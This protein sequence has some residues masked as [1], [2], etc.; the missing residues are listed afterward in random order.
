MDEEEARGKC[1]GRSGRKNLNFSS[2]NLPIDIHRKTTSVA[3]LS[4]VL[5]LL[6]GACPLPVRR[7]DRSN[8]N[9][10]LPVS[11]AGEDRRGIFRQGELRVHL[12]C[13]GAIDES[14]D[15]CTS[16]VQVL[17]LTFTYDTH[18]V[19]RYLVVNCA[20][21]RETARMARVALYTFQVTCTVPTDSAARPD[22]RS[23]SQQTRSIDCIQLYCTF[24]FSE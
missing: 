24:L 21:V 12:P 16:R 8:D 17:Y 20:Y 18:C 23:E 6:A 7:R 22:S 11:R 4:P 1:H 2:N 13:Q 10:V 3:Q 19:L 9:H 14:H 5:H 15:N